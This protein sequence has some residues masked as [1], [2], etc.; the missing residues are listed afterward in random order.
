M[1]R[2]TRAQKIQEAVDALN[3]AMVMDDPVH[4][5]I[6]F[7]NGLDGND[8]K[9]AELLREIKKGIVAYK[10]YYRLKKLNIE[11]VVV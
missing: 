3:K 9:A 10:K 2:K 4:F 11:F 5:R 8:P 7:P 1:K 6:W